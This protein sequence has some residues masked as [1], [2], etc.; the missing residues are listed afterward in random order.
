MSEKLSSDGF[1]DEDNLETEADVELKIIAPLLVGPNYLNIDSS[2]IRSKD[3]L[4]P[5]KLDKRAGKHTGYY[6]DF[7]VWID[8]IPALIVEAKNPT[9]DVY[10]GYREAS[11]YARHLN[12]K[13]K[14]G[15]NPCKFILSCNGHT[16]LCGTWDSNPTIDLPVS[17]LGI[18]TVNVERLIS[19]CGAAILEEHAQQCVSALRSTKFYLPY[20]RAGGQPLINSK[21]AFNSFSTDLAPILRRYFTSTTQNSD[22][23]IYER[24]YVGS[25]DVTAYDRVLESLLKERIATRKGTI[26]QDLSPSRKSE[27]KLSAAISDFQK[28]KSKAGQLQLITG[29]VGSGKS[30]FAR[31]FKEVLQPRDQSIVSHWAFIDFNNAPAS[32]DTAEHWLCQSFIDNF[33]LENPHFDPYSNENLSRIFSRQ[34]Q[35]RKGIYDELRKVSEERAQIRRAEDLADW[36][37]DYQKIAFGICHHFLGQRDDTVIVVMDNVDRLNLENQLAAF[38]LA[39]W[40][41]DQSGAFVMLQMRDETYERFK[42]KPPLDTFKSGIVFHIKPPRF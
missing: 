38:Q 22:P 34:L 7:S 36:Q 32:L 14:P 40:F 3:Y 35:Q 4:S 11:L 18:A 25:E 9:V 31:R 20:S 10:V 15:L 2:Y 39:L 16:L 24:A 6:P 19:H 42:N 1:L 23:A 28:R 21:R 30:L 29:G 37:N 26:T 27:P 33:Q 12:Q 17:A 13:Y 41:M 8:A 5:T